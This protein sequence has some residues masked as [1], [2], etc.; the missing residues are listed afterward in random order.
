MLASRVDGGPPRFLPSLIVDKT[1]GLH[2][3]MARAGAAL[4]HRERK[5]E[6]QMIEVPMLETI[7]GFWLAEH[8]FNGTYVP[9]RGDM[10]Y[11]RVLSA[12]PQ[13]LPDQ[14]WARLRHRLQREALAR[15]RR[16]ARPARIA[17]GP[18]L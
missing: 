18:A 8:L 16:E 10:G 3:A 15:V 7:T 13:A 11:A 2:L 12:R 1:T 9:A 5:G 17:H 4:V 6:G 14:R